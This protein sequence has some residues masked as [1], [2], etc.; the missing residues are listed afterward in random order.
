MQRL[1]V[2]KEELEEM[3][4]RVDTDG[5]RIISFE[6]FTSLMR[7]IDHTRASAGLRSR[8]DEI[9]SDRDGR[10]S[11]DEFRAWVSR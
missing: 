4:G 5:D 11:F 2:A 3:F 9:D 7:G 6:E 8:F 1:N 10:V